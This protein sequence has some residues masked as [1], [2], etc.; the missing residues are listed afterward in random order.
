MQDAL[1]IKS[2]GPLCDDLVDINI[3]TILGSWGYFFED[4]DGFGDANS[5]VSLCVISEGFSSNPDDCDDLDSN[6]HP[7]AIEFCDY[8]DNNCDG[9]IDETSAADAMDPSDR[10]S[11]IR[12]S[13][14]VSRPPTATPGADQR[15]QRSQ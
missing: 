3:L 5:E 11:Q 15:D 4:F 6:V 9:V 14:P 7:T 8:L 12:G 10:E 2:W 1:N 13:K